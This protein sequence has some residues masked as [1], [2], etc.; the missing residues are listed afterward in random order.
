[1]DP[2]L[3]DILTN[4]M[5]GSAGA[6]A[7]SPFGQFTEH[8]RD[9]FDQERASKASRLNADPLTMIDP[10]RVNPFKGFM[11]QT[12]GVVTDSGVFPIE[13]KMPSTNLLPNA[14]LTNMGEFQSGGLA[15][16]LPKFPASIGMDTINNTPSNLPGGAGGFFDL[17][18]LALQEN[19]TFTIPKTQPFFESV[20]GNKLVYQ[21]RPQ[22]FGNNFKLGG[23]VDQFG[24][25]NRVKRL[26]RRK[27][28]LERQGK[29][30][31][32]RYKNAVAR[33]QDIESGGRGQSG[34]GTFLREAGKGVPDFLL[35]SAGFGDIIDNSFVDRSGFLTG[36]TNTISDV[37]TLALGITNPL[38]GAGL[39]ALQ[40]LSNQQFGN[41]QSSGTPGGVGL[42]FGSIPGLVPDL[43]NFQS[44]FQTGSLLA[45][46]QPN[47]GG[48]GSAPAPLGQLPTTTGNIFGSPM[49]RS[50]LGNFPGT[51]GFFQEGGPVTAE[52]PIPLIPIQTEMGEMII[53][54]D[55]TITKVN[56]VKK[57]K[58]MDKD[59]VTDI[60]PEGTYIASNDKMLKITFDEA[61]EI[62]MAIKALPYEEE[63][64]GV[65]PEEVTFSDL[66][67]GNSTRKMTPAELANRIRLKYGTVDKERLFDRSDIFTEMT[68]KL[69]ME[70]RMP[71]IAELIG[72][73]EEKRGGDDTDLIIFGKGGKVKRKDVEHKP[74][75]GNIGN[76]LQIGAAALPFIQ[77]LFGGGQQ[78]ASGVDP[79]ARSMILGSAPLAGLGIQQNINA[80]QGVR[81]QAI[82][83]FTGL[84]QVLNNFA[85]GTT[86]ANI[87]GRQLQDTD[88]ERF[89]PSAQDTRLANFNTRTPRS[90]VDALSTPNFDLQALASELGPRGFNT[91]ASNLVSN[92][93]R[94]RNEALMNQFNQ[95]RNL[96]LNILGQ[97]NA[98]DTFTQ[99]FNIGQGEKEQAAR[100]AV[101]AGT[102]GDIGSLFGRLGDIQSNILPI[103]TDF[104]FQRAALEGQIPLLTSQNL[105]NTGSVLAS[106][107]TGQPGTTAG[108]GAGNLFN[109]IFPQKSGGTGVGNFFRSI[110]GGSRPGVPAPF[111]P[112]PSRPTGSVTST[113]ST[114][115][116]PISLPGH[117]TGKCPPG[118]ILING[119]CVQ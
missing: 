14:K 35:S 58:S 115:A 85:F 81:D 116:P 44:N 71:W 41:N 3:L 36:L 27:E 65:V 22:S 48:F 83:D 25:G 11:A 23:A 62:A 108:G 89:N 67:P 88:F 29:T 102:F 92:Q 75:G 15:G 53:H 110:F 82:Q 13:L 94:S 114:T 105:M 119:R 79:L 34:V 99:Q 33:L 87:L 28:K 19:E 72:L 69:N 6:V 95:Q 31:T 60:V 20:F 40:G 100:N 5:G 73:N 57:H 59:E 68:N 106:L 43:A 38:A 113:T 16:A 8:L 49:V 112:L 96:D 32:K 52:E 9:F 104:N 80:Q 30:D 74:E 55:G 42:G 90:F 77:S 98:L 84:G 12:G 109:S 21:H 118:S 103:L 7:G 56:A 66:W 117:L 76:I 24:L 1:M 39:A 97:R 64:R 37:G 93:M 46:L 101:T 18:Q 4:F 61:E 50:P 51:P 45:G 54:L 26:T 63:K 17:S 86:G 91:F 111:N 107:G 78:A 10:F 2:L 47:L 70:S